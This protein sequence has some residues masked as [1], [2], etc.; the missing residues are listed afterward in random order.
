MRHL[1]FII[2]F[3]QFPIPATGL[4][5]CLLVP[6]GGFGKHSD[7]PKCCFF[8]LVQTIEKVRGRSGQHVVLTAHHLPDAV[9]TVKHVGVF[10]SCR[11]RTTVANEGNMKAEFDQDQQNG[12]H[13]IQ[14]ISGRVGFYCRDLQMAAH[15]H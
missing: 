13:S 7:P 9:P 15:Q 10:V 4:W 5:S 11:G 1:L 8:V 2:L 6:Y 12:S 14:L 3:V